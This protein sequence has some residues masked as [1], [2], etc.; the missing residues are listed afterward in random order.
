MM[1]LFTSPVSISGQARPKTGP[2]APGRSPLV[3]GT[4]SIAGGDDKGGCREPTGPTFGGTEPADEGRRS[5]RA[6]G[7]GCLCG[8]IVSGAATPTSGWRAG[9]VHDTTGRPH[10]PPDW[11]DERQL[12]PIEEGQ[13][14]ECNYEQYG[15]GG[16]SQGL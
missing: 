4:S 12:R 15:A 13:G 9:P 8:T 7:R 1:A 14:Y 5:H 11:R 16:R 2:S 6:T 10:G 3:R